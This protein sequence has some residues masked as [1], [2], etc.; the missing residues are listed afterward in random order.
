MRVAFLG[1]GLIGGSVARALREADGWPDLHLVA[2]TPTGEGPRLAVADG[3][4]DL[5]A[6]SPLEAIG[7]SDLIVLAAPP[8]ECLRLLDELGGPWRTAVAPAAT[9]TDVAS[10]KAAVV[11]RADAYD[12]RFVGGHPMAGRETVGYG[13]AE[14]DLFAGQPWVV[15]AGQHA[16]DRDL[17]AVE[18]LATACRAR[19]LRLDAT[20]HDAVVA[21]T[22]HLPLILAAALVEA[23]AGPGDGDAESDRPF[24]PA[25]TAGGWRS[26]T[27]LARGDVAMGTGIMATNGPAIAQRIRDVQAVLNRWLADLERPGGP[28][29]AAVTHRLQAARDRLGRLD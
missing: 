11:A 3:V 22:S 1:F 21:G 8:L 10:T 7:G 24:I 27:R 13:A 26:I 15:V 29:T 17:Q 25:L 16:T 9:I 28:D 6:S 12:L 23:V 19:P 20:I 5:A 14:A 4:L 18:A 2:W